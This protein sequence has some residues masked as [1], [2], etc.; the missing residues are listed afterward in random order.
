M[1]KERDPWQGAP[2]WSGVDPD[3]LAPH[4]PMP[5]APPYPPGTAPEPAAPTAP[6]GAGPAL[7]RCLAAPAGWVA[8]AL[9]VAVVTGVGS[10][11]LRGLAL[12]LPWLATAAVLV[13]P[14]RR[15]AGPGLLVALA[16]GPFWLL[17]ALAVELLGW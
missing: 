14:A 5:G 1:G 7:P 16:F 17:H 12:V 2:G 13:F 8:V 15:G 3:R 10:W 11:P 4:E 6:A 9:L